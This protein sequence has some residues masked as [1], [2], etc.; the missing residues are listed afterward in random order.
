[1]SDPFVSRVGGVISAD[2]AV[3][4]HQRMQRFYA[5]VL[6]T[7]AKPCWRDDLMNSQGVPVIGL[8]A[9]SEEY[10]ALPVQWMPHI[11]VSDVAASVERA[12]NMGGRELMHGK[13]AEGASQWA[14]LLDPNGTA[15]GLIPV[16]SPDL[17]PNV[18]DASAVGCIA[19]LDLT[20]SNAAAT[21]DFYRAVIEWSVQELAMDD[22]GTAYADYNMCGGDN[23]SAAGICHARGA[24]V[25]IPATWMI[26]FPVG[27]LA[28]SLQHV[29]ELGGDVIKATR[30]T[31]GEYA[32][33]II[34]DPVGACIGLVPASSDAS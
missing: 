7:G 1:M 34:R 17:I 26:Y 30:G 5:Q 16:V 8:G 29:A 11:Q 23:N 27:D 14:V 15:F 28:T 21:R 33:A 9:Q 13:D 12:L 24:N 10:A 22:A 20:V 6:T 19:W 18:D 2:I 4:E 25:D 32:Y 31:N 3:P